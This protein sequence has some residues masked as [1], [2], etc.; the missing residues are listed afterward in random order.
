MIIWDCIVVGAGIAGS[1]VSNRLLEQDPSLKILLIEAGPNTHELGDLTVIDTDPDVNRNH[2]WSFNS[3]PQ[4]N[5]DNRTMSSLAGK[6]LG[7]GTAINGG[8]WVRGHKA[9]YD[10]W[11]E[12]VA[13]K[14]WTYEGQLP[15]MRKT[16]TLWDQATNPSSHGHRGPVK[17][18]NPVDMGR[19]F[20]LR[21]PLIDSWRELGVNPLPSFD[22][23]A[24]NS[25]GI[26]NMQENKN[27][28]KRQLA[29]QIYPLDGIAILTDS[30]VARVLVERNPKGPLVCR[31]I[32]LENGTKIF[33][34]ETI[35]SAGAY[36]T[37]QILMLSGIG[38]ADT[39][40]KH[41][42]NVV[43]EQPAVG[44]NLHDHVLLPTIWHL[45]NASEGWAKGSGNPIFEQPQYDLGGFV[46][47]ITATNLPREGLADSIAQDEGGLS[48]DPKLHPLLN[49][50]RAASSH[51]LM[52][53]GI[54]ADGSAVMLVSIVLINT[55]RGSVS[56]QSADIKDD[57]IID[58]NFLGT[59]F[60]RFAARETMREAVRL[61]SSNQT[62]MGRLIVD[63]DGTDH[64]LTVDSPDEEV[65][66]RVRESTGGC[67]HPAGTAAMGTVVDGDL[68]V[69]GVSGLRVVDTSVFPVSISANLQ[70]AAYALGEQAA[71]VI[72]STLWRNVWYW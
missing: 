35:L 5:A 17:I 32:Q 62:I 69:M 44:Q 9:D 7:G 71:D 65:D 10:L 63:G 2:T 61:M 46:D 53:G 13:D 3:V 41:G 12:K 37:P 11:G 64:P 48:P 27:H 68:R 47:L 18:Q 54:S 72:M 50:D 15:Y 25:L 45:A 49:R 60:D 16:E 51:Q 67:Y 33:A 59:N 36:R 21:E 8:A 56:I 43:L 66:A 1:V 4:V 70:V 57:P 28:G 40:R 38:P 6:G 22:A 58:P 39:L 29:S 26:G 55:S 20:P 24:G 19:I 23:N 31:G 42:I 52:H 14:R 34:R 30:L